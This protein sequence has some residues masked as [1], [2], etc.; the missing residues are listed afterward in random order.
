MRRTTPDLTGQRKTV[1][2][3]ISAVLLGLTVLYA[4]WTN[5]V[6]FF[7]GN[8]P[9]TPIDLGEGSVGF[10]L[11]MLVIGDLMLVLVLWVVVDAVLLNL[12]HMVLLAGQRPSRPSSSPSQGTTSGQPAAW[13]QP[14]TQGQQSWQQPQWQGQ[15]PPGQQSWQGQPAQG[16][17]SWQGQQWQG[18]PSQGQQSWPGQQPSGS[19]DATLVG[20][21]SPNWSPPDSSQPR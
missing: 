8:L 14:P 4:L 11:T 12:L 5:Y 9:L 21:G 3:T 1:F 13:Q 20:Q 2:R 6:A 15:Q 10:G 17:Q 16:Q 7:G 18:Q 19:G